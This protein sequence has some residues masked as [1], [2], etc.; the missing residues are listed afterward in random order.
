M[1]L[2]MNVIPVHLRNYLLLLYITAT[3]KSRLAVMEL[4]S[5]E[6]QQTLL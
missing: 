3:V 4:K 5:E 6:E 1:K 2:D